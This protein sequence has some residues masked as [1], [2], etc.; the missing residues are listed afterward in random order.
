MCRRLR[1]I[2]VPDGSTPATYLFPEL[3]NHQ[4]SSVLLTAVVALAGV[5]PSAVFAAQPQ[6]WSQGDPSADEQYALELTQE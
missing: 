5:L 2:V 1:R 4:F 6:Q 3:K